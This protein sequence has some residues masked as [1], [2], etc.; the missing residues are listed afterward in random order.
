MK[1]LQQKTKQNSSIEWGKS[2]LIVIIIILIIKT[3]IFAPFKVEGAS[4]QPTLYND[5]RLIVN[6]I[7]M[8]ISSL[9]RG[10]VVVIKKENDAKY[11]VKRII[12][13]QKDSLKVVDGELF[14][15]NQ[16]QQESYLDHDLLNEYK[17]YLNV[18]EIKVPDEK[19][20]VMGDNR[21][22][23]KDSRNGLGYI[24]VSDIVGK[25]RFVYY[26]LDRIKIV[27]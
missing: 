25:S 14:I 18:K 1:Q 10:D 13:L 12:G 9:Q 11:Y 24:D 21:F 15:N 2:L 3:F 16:K 19:V 20:F 27:K 6:K 5:D 22:N 8:Q 26:P 4:M 7:A 23:S 17:E